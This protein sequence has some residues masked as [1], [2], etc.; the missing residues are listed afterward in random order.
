MRS[1]F[2]KRRHAEGEAELNITAFMNLMVVLVPFL[3]MMVVFSRITILELNLPKDGAASN[4]DEPAL[5]LE[6]VL[7]KD[8]LELA[9]HG[10]LIQAIPN[11]DGRYDLAALSKALRQIKA[12]SPETT[13]AT[14]LLEPQIKYDH[15]VGVMDTVRVVADN[16]GGETRKSE[17]FPDISIGDAPVRAGGS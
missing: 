2:R 16:V 13:T 4:Q 9:N 3:L 10:A 15:L 17:L 14:L 6:V 11:V 1:R 5:Q 7:R 8:R 12:G